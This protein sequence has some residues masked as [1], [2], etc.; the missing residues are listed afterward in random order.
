MIDGTAI[1]NSL[2]MSGLFLSKP[3]FSLKSNIALQSAAD[4]VSYN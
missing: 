3:I 1:A 2:T 4:G